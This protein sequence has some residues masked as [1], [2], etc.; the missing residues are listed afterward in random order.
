MGVRE[1]EDDAVP[2]CEAE[3]PQLSLGEAVAPMCA[4]GSSFTAFAESQTLPTGSL[5]PCVAAPAPAEE[6][7]MPMPLLP[8]PLPP[9]VQPQAA[10]LAVPESQVLLLQ[11]ADANED[12]ADVSTI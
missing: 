7:A 3:D 4:Q 8:L 1:V 2:G 12:D 11:E 10:T 5:V 6:A 9:M